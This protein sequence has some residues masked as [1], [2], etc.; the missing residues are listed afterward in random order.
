MIAVI[1]P[2]VFGDGSAFQGRSALPAGCAQQWLQIYEAFIGAR[3]RLRS[4]SRGGAPFTLG[5]TTTAVHD[6]APFFVVIRS[7]DL[8]VVGSPLA[9]LVAVTRRLGDE[10]GAV[11]VCASHLSVLPLLERG[12]YPRSDRRKPRMG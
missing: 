9:D 5:M 10:T 6:Q 12:I 8:R 2:K 7:S 1:D 4:Q 11:L 3:S